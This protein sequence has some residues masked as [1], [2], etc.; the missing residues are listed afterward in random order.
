VKLG[1]LRRSPKPVVGKVVHI[2]D[3]DLYI[4]FGGKFKVVCARPRNRGFLYR[5]GT[6]VVVALHDLEMTSRFLGAVRDTTLLEADATLLGLAPKFL[7]D[8]LPDGEEAEEEEEEE[9][10]GAAVNL[11]DT[12]S[13]EI[14]NLFFDPQR[15]ESALLETLPQE[16]LT[17]KQKDDVITNLF[18]V[19]DE[20]D[21]VFDETAY[22][23]GDN[24]EE[25]QKK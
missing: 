22:V 17:E 6:S 16:E 21:D 10:D 19:S 11:S 13:Y 20:T 23:S 15:V 7:S 1:N 3:D 18:D 4:E 8:G 12:L 25:D 2:V 24:A 5:K 9:E 14:D